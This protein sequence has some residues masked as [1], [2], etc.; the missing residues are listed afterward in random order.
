MAVEPMGLT[1]ISPVTTEL[2]TVEIP[3]FARIAK[4]PADPRFTGTTPATG[5]HPVVKVHVLLAANAL[6][7]RSVTPVVIVTV[8]TVLGVRSLVG[9]KVATV[10]T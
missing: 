2:G 3:D 9:L 7:T 8:T 4:L 1:P 5:P 10:P 6:P